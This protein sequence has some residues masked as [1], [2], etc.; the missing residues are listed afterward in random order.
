MTVQFNDLTKDAYR[1][2]AEE[3]QSFAPAPLGFYRSFGKRALDILLI[4]ST[5]V[6]TVP[7][8][9]IV[10]LLVALDGYNPF[11]RQKRVGKNNVVF[12][13]WKLRSM[14]PNAEQQLEAYLAANPSARQEWD[15]NQKLKYDPR[16]T[17]IGRFIRKT[18]IDELPQLWNVLR[19]DMSL[20]GPRPMMCE[21][22]AIYPG[23]AYYDLHPGISGFWQISDRNDTDFKSRALFDVKY[24]Q[25]VSLKTDILVLYRTVGAV[26]RCTGY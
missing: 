24:Q 7:L 20:I 13:M 10:A 5:A 4:L 15:T 22:R 9:A 11:F 16:I 17:R 25:D 19:G 26:L 18:S 23:A 8:I 6:L 14:V 12:G 1:I 2:K 3:V 21:Q